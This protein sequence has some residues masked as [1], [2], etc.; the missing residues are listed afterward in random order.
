MPCEET[1]VALAM[2]RQGKARTEA[3]HRR[4]CC[5]HP[6]ALGH[7]KIIAG[8]SVSESSFFAESARNVVIPKT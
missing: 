4:L 8:L 6:L 1:H 5:R 2:S 7:E 3:I